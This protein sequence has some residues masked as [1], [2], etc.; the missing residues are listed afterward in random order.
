MAHDHQALTG[1][2][3]R[4]R[5]DTGLVAGPA[6]NCHLGERDPAVLRRCVAANNLAVDAHTL[7]SADQDVLASELPVQALDFPAPGR[8]GVLWGPPLDAEQRPALIPI[9]TWKPS[10]K[11][12]GLIVEFSR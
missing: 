7:R 3:R 12:R 9:G 1:S 6:G 5:R 10:A 8:A 2:G 4:P 11:R